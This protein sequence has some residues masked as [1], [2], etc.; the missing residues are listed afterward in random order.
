MK[1][2]LHI[3]RTEHFPEFRRSHKQLTFNHSFIEEKR[4]NFEAKLFHKF[5]EIFHLR[6][7]AMA[8]WAPPIVL[9][10]ATTVIM[11]FVDM[12]FA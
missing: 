1:K 9:F 11:L 8:Q 5:A 12:V 4:F 2:S 7:G 10:V 6:K 3:L